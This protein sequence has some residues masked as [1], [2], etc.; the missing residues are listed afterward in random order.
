M[1]LG[2]VVIAL[3]FG[4]AGCKPADLLN[5]ISFPVKK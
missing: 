5:R 4:V 3:V 2:I 1:A